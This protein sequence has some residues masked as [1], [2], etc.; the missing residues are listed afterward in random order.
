MYLYSF[1]SVGK[2][3][4]AGLPAD[5]PMI[6]LSHAYLLRISSVVLGVVIFGLKG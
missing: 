3:R 6:N 1:L 5:S 4:F 2:D